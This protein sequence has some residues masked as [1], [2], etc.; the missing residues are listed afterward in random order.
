MRLAIEQL[1]V[2]VD[3]EED[4]TSSLDCAD[5]CLGKRLKGAL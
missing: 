2:Q 1:H 3:N 4:L 5:F